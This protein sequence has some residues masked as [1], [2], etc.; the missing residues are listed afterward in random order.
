VSVAT[1]ST[2]APG[3]SLIYEVIKDTTPVAMGYLPLGTA[4]GLLLA[5][6]DKSELD[7]KR[8]FLIQL[9]SHGYWILG[10]LLGALA[11]MVMSESINGIEFALTAL[12]VVLAQEH[13]Y[14][15]ENYPAIGLGLMAA[16]LAFAI[17]T[18]QFLSIAMALFVVLLTARFYKEKS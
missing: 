11:S 1:Q 10:S 16:G 14:K 12:F 3:K 6:K 2:P 8:I 4:Y 9:F 18:S 13:C 5:S 17:S 15:K 7:E